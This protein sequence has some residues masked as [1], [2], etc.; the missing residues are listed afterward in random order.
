MQNQTLQR[1]RPLS[2]IGAT[3][4]L[5]TSLVLAFLE[6]LSA[7]EACCGNRTTNAAIITTIITESNPTVTVVAPPQQSAPAGHAGVVEVFSAAPQTTVVGSGTAAASAGPRQ[8]AAPNPTAAG[9]APVR[10]AAA[11]QPTVAAVSRVEPTPDGY[12]IE[13]EAESFITVVKRQSPIQPTSAIAPLLAQAPIPPAPPA[14]AHH[15]PGPLPLPHPADSPHFEPLEPPFVAYEQALEHKQGHQHGD[16]CDCFSCDKFG[17]LKRFSFYSKLLSGDVGIGQERVAY[18]PFQIEQAEPFRNNR[19]RFDAAYGLTSP[20]RAQYFWAASGTGPAIP[21]GPIDYFDFRYTTESAHGKISL[22]TDIPI[23]ALDY[24]DTRSA[25]LGNISMATK[26]AIV[27]GEDWYVSSIMRMYLPLGAK[28]RGSSNGHFSLEPGLLSRYRFN[29]R[30]YLH[31]QAKWWIPFGGNSAF[32]GQVLNYGMGLSYVAYESDAFAMM[33]T[34]ELD[35]WA[36]TSGQKTLPGG[37]VVP[38]GGDMFVNI[39]PGIRY[40]MGPSGDLGLFEFGVMGGFQFGD[41]GWYTHILRTELRWS[42]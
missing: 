10:T 16:G 5:A 36:V 6:P 29:D 4:W 37:T 14:D 15:E 11:S 3:V 9:R 30:L 28:E 8:A 21:N 18:A 35:G 42:F 17:P 25:G 27:S 2:S 40:V 13:A 24:E 20:D 1:R 23:R 31:G 26:T 38:V 19:L 12:L 22:I 32:N 41:E 33:P 34:L 7:D 39:L